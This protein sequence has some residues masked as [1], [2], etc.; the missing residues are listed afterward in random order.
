V[1]ALASF[2]E[3]TSMRILP[4]VAFMTLGGEPF[5]RGYGRLMAGQAIETGMTSRESEF[6]L[7]IVIETPELPAI[8]VVTNGAVASEPFLV[9]V[10]G[11]V[12][13]CTFKRGIL[14]SGARVASLASR[15]GM[16]AEQRESRQVMVEKHR[17]PPT[18]G[19]MAFPALFAL[20]ASMHILLEMT[21]FAFQRRFAKSKRLFM[22]AVAFGVRVLRRQSEFGLVMIEPAILPFICLMAGIAFIAQAPLVPIVEAMT[23]NAAAV[24][25]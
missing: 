9:D 14:E 8:G 2:A 7:G 6:G 3:F 19:V 25:R 10:P 15:Q 1:T 21:A 18:F 11:R 20:L 24:E 22:A 16:Q 17:L 12:A 23:G 13:F 4:E 5:I